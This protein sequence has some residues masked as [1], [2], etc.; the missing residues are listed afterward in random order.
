[1]GGWTRCDTSG[2]NTLKRYETSYFMGTSRQRLGDW[3]V[4]VSSRLDTGNVSVSSRTK[5]SMS[6]SRLGLGAGRLWSRLGLALRRLVDI[7]VNITAMNWIH[8]NH[9]WKIQRLYIILLTVVSLFMFNFTVHTYFIAWSSTL[10]HWPKIDAKHSKTCRPD[11][12]LNF[13]LATHKCISL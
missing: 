7:P 3:N 9:S 10:V 8:I 13:M 2:T 11:Y 5:C 1:M 4:S 6:R 12:V